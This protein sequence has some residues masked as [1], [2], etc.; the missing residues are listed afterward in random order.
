MAL[1]PLN[2]KRSIR[3]AGSNVQADTIIQLFKKTFM[4]NLGSLQAKVLKKIVVD[5]YE[6]V[7][8]FDDDITPGID[9]SP[10]WRI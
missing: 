2:L 5:T 3:M 4:P 1:I 6:K 7:G 10:R 8:I 9:R